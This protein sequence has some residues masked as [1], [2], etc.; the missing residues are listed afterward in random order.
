[1]KQNKVGCIILSI[2]GELILEVYVTETV[3]RVH[4]LRPSSLE[5]ADPA[6]L[7]TLRNYTWL[8]LLLTV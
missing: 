6:A 7:V 1:M 8:I 3:A 5:V 2:E 4:I